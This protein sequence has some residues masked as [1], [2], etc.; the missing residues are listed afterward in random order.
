MLR[1]R[2]ACFGADAE[3]TKELVKHRSDSAIASRANRFLIEYV[4]AQP[5]Q[6]GRLPTTHGYYQMLGLAQEIIDRGTAS[7]FLHYGLA[8]FEV[9]ILE[10]GRL[11]ISRDEPVDSRHQGRTPAAG[12]RASG[13]PERLPSRFLGWHRRCTAQDIRETKAPTRCAASMASRCPTSA[14]YAAVFS[15][16]GTA[17]QVTASPRRRIVSDSRARRNLDPDLVNTVLNAITLTPR[18]KSL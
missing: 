10:S 13:N 6:G 2:L 7:D 15:T 9:A 8:D 4:A 3:T 1:S 18:G 16:L 12:R 17:D 11:G 5:P 14:R